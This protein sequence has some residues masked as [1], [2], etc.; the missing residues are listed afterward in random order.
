MMTDDIENVDA[1]KW[2][3]DNY[4]FFDDI[5]EDDGMYYLEFCLKEDAL[6]VI[7]LCC[8]HNVPFAFRPPYGI[9]IAIVHVEM[10]IRKGEYAGDFNIPWPTYFGTHPLLK[11]H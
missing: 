6:S 8:K 3:L 5:F 10:L 1:K 4:T 11:L 7:A 9:A 2:L